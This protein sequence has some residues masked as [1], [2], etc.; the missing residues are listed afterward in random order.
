MQDAAIYSALGVREG[1]SGHLDVY[2]EAGIVGVMLLLAFLIACYCNALRQLSRA[3]DWGLF[4]ICLLMMTLIHNFTER[5][6]LRPS[7]YFWNSLI[8]VA[9]VFTAP[10][11]GKNE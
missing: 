9:I 7:S 2:L 8:F 6:F 10:V 1:H 11:L 3:Y 4:G 5:N